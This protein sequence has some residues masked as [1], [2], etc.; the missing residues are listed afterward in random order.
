MEKTSPVLKQSILGFNLLNEVSLRL[1][2][3]AKYDYFAIIL[4][5]KNM[6]NPK[7]CIKVPHYDY[8]PCAHKYEN[9][10]L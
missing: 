3:K 9:L 8:L 4:I 5:L 2:F 10:F 6:L 7:L 1:W